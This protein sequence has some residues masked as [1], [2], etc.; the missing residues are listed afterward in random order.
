MLGT[1]EDTPLPDAERIMRVNWLAPFAVLQAALPHL[2]VKGGAVVN[3]ASDQA[4]VGKKASAAY[5]AS[6][7]AIAQMTR[8]A[9]L[10]YARPAHGRPVRFNAVA[11]CS[12]DTPMLRDVIAKLAARGAPSS[13]DAYT[14][15]VPQGRFAEPRE[16]AAVIA[17]LLSDHASFVTG[18][19][20]PVDG[21][22]TAA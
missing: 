4:F 3:V 15:A 2:L 10:D 5:G 13:L 12:T 9:A 19:V 21:G 20:M 6:K 11:P 22:T 8:S 16:I 14:D 18:V 7:G 17:F 1:L